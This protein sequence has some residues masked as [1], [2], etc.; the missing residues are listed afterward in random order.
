MKS[1]SNQATGQGGDCCFFSILSSG[2]NFVQPRGTIL[3]TFGK[4][5]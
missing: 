3:A 4:G 5:P 2:N 1:F